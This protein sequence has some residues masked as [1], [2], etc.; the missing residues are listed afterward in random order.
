M[1]FA[2]LMFPAKLRVKVGRD[3]DFV[4]VSN[5]RGHGLKSR[6][7][8]DQFPSQKE[9]KIPN[10]KWGRSHVVPYESRDGPKSKSG[11]GLGL[12]KCAWSAVQVGRDWDFVKVSN[13]RGH[14][15]KSLES[16]HSGPWG[17]GSKSWLANQHV[18][19]N[20]PTHLL[21]MVQRVKPLCFACACAFFGTNLEGRD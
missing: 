1:S 17:S 20:V 18:D 3:G 2:S 8:L 4:K 12:F 9:A 5:Q 7:C 10:S 14:G 11:S 19:G 13:Q 15:P 16:R 6:G 21:R